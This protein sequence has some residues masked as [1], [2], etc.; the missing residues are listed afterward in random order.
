MTTKLEYYT[1]KLQNA[2]TPAQKNKYKN[3]IK[4]HTPQICSTTP[5][6]N[7]QPPNTQPPN[8][9]PRFIFIPSRAFILSPKLTL[10]FGK[11]IKDMIK[12]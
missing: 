5:P 12:I 9:Q 3:K 10:Y 2:K 1:H 4:K 6:P 11:Q 7:T 8:T